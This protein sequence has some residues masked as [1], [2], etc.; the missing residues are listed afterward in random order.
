MR[1]EY[2]WGAKKLLAVLHRRY[3]AL[4][5][6]ARVPSTI[7]CAPSAAAAAPAPPALDAPGQRAAD[8]TQPNQV[9]PADFRGEFKTGDGRYCYPLTKPII[10]VACCWSARRCP[11][12]AGRRPAR[13]SHAVSHRRTA[14]R[15]PHDN[16]SPFASPAIHGLSALNV[17]W[18]QLGI[19]HQRIAPAS[20]QRTG[21]INGCTGSSNARPPA[22][23][24]PRPTRSSDALRPSG[25]EIT[26]SGPT[27][28]W[29]TPRPRRAGSRRHD[30]IRSGAG[31]RNMTRTWKSDASAAVAP[32]PGRAP[33]F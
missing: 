7:C 33:S 11:R 18:M 31:D 21:P 6:P 22:R 5:W 27:R 19:V 10:T 23:R 3:P 16:G 14:G 29:P 17:W 30:P 15:D 25:A 26:T 9:W 20:P 2:G 32:S 24:R 8:T 4:E 12:P 28:R 1:R 13:V